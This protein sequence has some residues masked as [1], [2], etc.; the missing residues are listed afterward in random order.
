MSNDHDHSSRVQIHL[1]Y[2]CDERAAL[3]RLLPHALPEPGSAERI[4]QHA[5]ILINRIREAESG[6]WQLR[7]LLQDY[8]LDTDEG[9]AL[10]CLAEALL[11]VPD[12]DTADRLIADKLGAAQWL[13]DTPPNRSLFASATAWALMLGKQTVT[14]GDNTRWPQAH[15]SLFNRLSAPVVR[16][17]L[18]AAMT[19]LGDLFVFGETIAEATARAAAAGA[20]EYFSFDMLGE[21]A[22]SAKQANGYFEQYQHA[23]EHLAK[24]P[25]ANAHRHALSVKL[26]ALH[27]T[28]RPPKR[29]Q[30]IAAL[31]P[32]L[33]ALCEAAMAADIGLCLD[34]EESDRLD[35]SLDLLEKLLGE[36]SLRHWRGLG[37]A[38]QA[39]QKRALPLLQWLYQQAATRQHPLQVRLVKGAYWDTEIK[40]CQTLGL[41]DFP[42][43][44]RK[45]STDV[46][47]L[48]CARYL[49]DKRP[50]LYPQFATHNAHT[51]ASII[52][53]SGAKREG[54][55]LQR[56]HGMGEVVHQTINRDQQIATRI[57][58]P[59]GPRRHLLPYLVRRLLENGANSSF[60]SRVAS[61]DAALAQLT[62]HPAIVAQTL[63]PVMNPRITRPDDLFMPMRKNSSGV[64][65]SD[66]LRVDE[67]LRQMVQ[68]NRQSLPLTAVPIINQPA[69]DSPRDA[70]VAPTSAAAPHVV[71][72]PGNLRQTLGQVQYTTAAQAAEALQC[73]SI[74]APEWRS[75]STAQRSAMLFKVAELLEHEK[76]ALMALCVREAGKTLM[77]A[78]AEVREAVDF[79]RYYATTAQQLLAVQLLPGVVGET[80]QLHWQGRGPFLC[81]SPWNFPLAIFTGQAMAALVAGNP[82]LLKPAEQTSLIA[83][84][85]TRLFHR[86]GVPT[87]ALQLL[88]G[89]GPDLA[90]VLLAHPAL[91]GVAFTG[92]VAAAHNIN[93]TLATR[94]QDI[95]PL[96][97][98]TGG[99]NAMIVDST[100][101]PEQVVRDVLTSAFVSAGQRCSCLRL[102]FLQDDTADEL[103]A[104]LQ[105]AMA[106]LQVGDPGQL[107]T[108][109]GPLIDATAVAAVAQHIERMREN[110]LSIYQSP[111][112]T[113][114]PPGHFVP[115]TLIELKPG[116]ALEGE[117][118]GPV[119]HVVRYAAD[120]VDEVIQAI[121]AT[122]FGLTLGIHS[123]IDSFADYVAR[124]VNVGN[125]YINRHMTGAVV[126]SQPFGGQG[127]SGTGFK[128]GGPHYLYRFMTEKC[129]S[130][131]TT[132][133]G[134]NASLLGES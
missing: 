49:L 80:N 23:I 37:L 113:Q 124:H 78:D 21:A 47:Y 109:V 94:T 110:A 40:Q 116:T 126:G 131:D 69:A 63:N 14:D 133:A 11:R 53:M 31:Y 33:L 132:A 29:H 74:Y 91:K 41:S 88:P 46:S 35:L 103:L 119:L 87:S 73:A 89:D 68:A 83:A 104:L 22:C 24:N 30:V 60:V 16:S 129:I 123:R 107:A 84:A 38:V 76:P 77:D 34:A 4:E 108:D 106:E 7:Q 61:S 105:G 122:G 81:I 90:A 96:I 51:L 102:L 59:V 97:A 134:G 67:L 6:T 120:D 13:T 18:R 95:I 42:V 98:E 66:S 114:L 44:T 25:H 112:P 56:L 128:A 100:A 62:Q 130:I 99:Q 65:F 12:P 75:T 45:V 36:P 92:S 19:A 79:C 43:F 8:G 125:V 115:P 5:A 52:E 57:Y 85:A 17:A 82:V 10:M 64:D 48:A 32:K 71:T 9:V 118:F 93:A 1:E 28:Y 117:V 72:N 127:M 26:S 111:L 86:A 39:Y 54:F 70:V 15:R 50:L 121:N 2:R 3:T 58:A 27:P 55:E 101:L 20:L